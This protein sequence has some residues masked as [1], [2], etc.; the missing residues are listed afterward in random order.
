M[1]D[2]VIAICSVLVLLGI[3]TKKDVKDLTDSSKDEL[4]YELKDTEDVDDSK[5]Q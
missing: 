5:E 4:L 3:V 2:V 1:K